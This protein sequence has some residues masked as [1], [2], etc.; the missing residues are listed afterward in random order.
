MQNVSEI[1]ADEVL[2][3]ITEHF[4]KRLVDHQ[5]VALL[6]QGLV[7]HGGIHDHQPKALFTFRLGLFS[8]FTRGDV[9]YKVL[10]V[11][12][13]PIFR[14][15]RSNAPRCPE[16]GA[17]LA[18]MFAF[19]VVDDSFNRQQAGVGNPFL[20]SASRN[21]GKQPIRSKPSGGEALEPGGFLRPLMNALDNAL[22][23]DAFFMEILP[24]SLKI[25]P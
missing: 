2:S 6:V 19:I 1:L 16:T 14:I 24:L 8:L 5:E 22:Q 15:D 12:N 11:G 7:G 18:N 23:R 25:S 13:A 21:E 3:T 17:I 10:I 20:G 9:A 4:Q